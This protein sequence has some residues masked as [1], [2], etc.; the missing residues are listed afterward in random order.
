MGRAEGHPECRMNMK[1]G[2]MPIGE[3][4]KRSNGIGSELSSVVGYHVEFSH[5]TGAIRWVTKWTLLSR[6]GREALG[7]LGWLLVTEHWG[8]AL[9][10]A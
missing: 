4:A 6:W 7:R 3:S 5:H 9:S 2:S 10:Q 1:A 8:P